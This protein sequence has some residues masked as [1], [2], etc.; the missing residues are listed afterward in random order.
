[1]K[2]QF[3]FSQKHFFFFERH[4]SDG[5]VARNCRKCKQSKHFV[6]RKNTITRRCCQE[7]R[8]NIPRKVF[9]TTRKC[10]ENYTKCKKQN[11]QILLRRFWKVNFLRWLNLCSINRCFA[12]DFVLKTWPSIRQVKALKHRRQKCQVILQKATNH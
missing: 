3:F 9:T 1:M 4:F 6:F 12:N 8:E 10:R 11:V 7:R 5:K 2:T